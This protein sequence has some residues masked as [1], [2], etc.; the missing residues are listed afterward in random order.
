MRV[1]IICGDADRVILRGHSYA[2]EAHQL[3][4]CIVRRARGTTLFDW[5]RVHPV[6]R[7]QHLLVSLY[8]VEQFQRKPTEVI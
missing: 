7:I 2:L 4:N 1:K 5:L 6:H 3:P 8:V